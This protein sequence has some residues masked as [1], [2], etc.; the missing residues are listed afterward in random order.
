MT[1]LKTALAAAG[2]VV[3]ALGAAACI[4]NSNEKTEPAGSAQTSV[5]P[6]ANP[7][8]PETPQTNP[9]QSATPS[10]GSETAPSTPP[11]P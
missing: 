11:S 5:D 2:A 7:T 8:P 10:A 6:A 4:P 3:L 1:K 9:D